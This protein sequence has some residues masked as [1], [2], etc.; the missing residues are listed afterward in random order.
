MCQGL[1][2]EDL[3]AARPR[4]GLPSAANV[5]DAA[6]AGSQ[7]EMKRQSPRSLDHHT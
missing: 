6:Q 1:R 2:P 7:A 3:S 5:P 4:E